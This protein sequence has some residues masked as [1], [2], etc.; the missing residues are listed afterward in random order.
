MVHEVVW[1]MN[2]FSRITQRFTRC[3]HTKNCE[4]YVADSYDCNFDY[5]SRCGQRRYKDEHQ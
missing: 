3:R 1:N 2:I 5:G 4:Y